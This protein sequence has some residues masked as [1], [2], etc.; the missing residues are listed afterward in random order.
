VAAQL[1]II[2]LG[3][4]ALTIFS[5]KARD[6]YQDRMD[7][8]NVYTR[9]AQQRQIFELFKMYPLTGLG[10]A[11]FENAAAARGQSLGMYKGYEAADYPHSNL[12]AILS[13]TGLLGFIPY[14]AAQVLVII[15]FRKLKTPETEESRT[16]WISFLYVTLS[17]WISGMSLTSGY[18]SDLNLWYVFVLMVIYKYAITR[19]RRF[20]IL[21]ATE[22]DSCGAHVVAVQAQA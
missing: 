12:G 10:I 22:S 9:I 4:G 7:R 1:A 6:A 19:V 16:V 2:A 20:C 17:Y 15:C 14:V 21:P 8:S 3:F 13:E 11:N 5:M 18:Y